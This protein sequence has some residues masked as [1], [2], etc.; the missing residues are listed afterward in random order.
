MDALRCLQWVLWLAC[1]SVLDSLSLDSV[2][3]E[4]ISRER[5]EH[6]HPS[7]GGHCRHL[8]PGHGCWLRVSN[9]RPLLCTF[10]CPLTSSY[11]L[12]CT[13]FRCVVSPKCHSQFCSPFFHLTPLL[14][15]V[16]SFIWARLSPSPFQGPQHALRNNWSR[17]LKKNLKKLFFQ[18]DLFSY[19]Y[20]AT[21]NGTGICR[22]QGPSNVRSNGLFSVFI[23]SCRCSH[24]WAVNYIYHVNLHCMCAV[25]L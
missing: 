14:C 21:V 19:I 1:L 20:K 2:G 6:S 3:Q 12:L 8:I 13:I 25:C 22:K 15:V 9:T 18:T 10:L 5:H 7:R 11:S 23:D 16:Y 24:C 4:L 17:C